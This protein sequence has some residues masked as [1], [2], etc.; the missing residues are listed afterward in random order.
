MKY[1]KKDVKLDTGVVL[2][3][4]KITNVVLNF[5]KDTAK[6]TFSGYIDTEMLLQNKSVVTNVQEHMV[7]GISELLQSNNPYY[8]VLTH[9]ITQGNKLKGSELLDTNA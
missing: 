6:M 3:C 1:L 8:A 7:G 5:E 2:T 4:W 9:I